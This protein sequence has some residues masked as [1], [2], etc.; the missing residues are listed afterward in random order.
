VEMSSM[1]CLLDVK[2][3][4]LMYFRHISVQGEKS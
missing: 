3:D 2:N 4:A 1:L